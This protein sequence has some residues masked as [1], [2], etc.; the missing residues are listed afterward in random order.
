MTK[1]P[2]PFELSGKN[3]IITGASS[4][5]GRTCAIECS[6]M[7]AKLSLI[8]R[9]TGRLAETYEA[10]EGT[11]HLMLAQDISDY[12]SIETLV[13]ESV[14]KLGPIDGFIHSAGVG[15][16]LPMRL[17]T[18]AHFEKI[19]A[20]NVFA[21]FEFARQIAKKKHI[22]AT[23]GSMVFIASVSG[24]K[25]E[26]AKI[27]YSSSKAALI[28]GVRTLALEYASKKI[29][30]NCVSPAVCLTRMAQDFLDKLSEEG[31]RELIL[32]HPL[33]LGVPEDVAYSCIFL[34]S[35]AS[36]WITG[37]NLVTDGGY[38]VH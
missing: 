4:G 8:G 15:L 34:L 10:M 32:Q 29:R 20:I 12:T 18:P 13:A 33:G 19:F 14:M 35:D 37:S 24:I 31:R 17:M 30:A 7:G 1:Y 27:G 23:G 5:I 16:N 28:N 38:S 21:A 25:A 9:D 3:I 26:A 36:R 22:R 2:N 11:G 6:R